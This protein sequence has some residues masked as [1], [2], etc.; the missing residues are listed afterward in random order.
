MKLHCL[1]ELLGEAVHEASMGAQHEREHNDVVRKRDRLT[2]KY[3][4]TPK[5]HRPSSRRAQSHAVV[6]QHLDLHPV[7]QHI[8]HMYPPRSGLHSTR[9]T[10]TSS[11][12]VH[13]KIR[14]QH[15]AI[16]YAGVEKAPTGASTWGYQTTVRFKE[17]DLFRPCTQSN[18]PFRDNPHRV[19]TSSSA[20]TSAHRP[21][22]THVCPRCA[23]ACLTSLP[24][25]SV[26]WSLCLRT[27]RASSFVMTA[28]SGFCTEEHLPSRAA[29][30]QG[31]W[32]VALFRP[33][34]R[35]TAPM[36]TVTSVWCHSTIPD[37]TRR[38]ELKLLSHTM[39]DMGAARAQPNHWTGICNGL[40]K[41]LSHFP[42]TRRIDSHRAKSTIACRRRR[43]PSQPLTC[44]GDPT[45]VGI[46][47]A[48]GKNVA[49]DLE[50]R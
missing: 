49:L 43:G 9:T 23:S 40:C 46:E 7:Q 16:Q 32:A 24:L 20:T 48:F 27:K 2:S 39:I 44:F 10:S 50:A 28:E 11:V 41:S 29:N 22:R 19:R 3:N 17:P 30:R 1:A 8:G 33:I 4:Q 5:S 12:A 6:H 47:F 31:T 18:R 21:H 38:S 45:P 37:P 15:V 36:C 25:P 26:P 42:R 14:V 13:R 34:P 35:T